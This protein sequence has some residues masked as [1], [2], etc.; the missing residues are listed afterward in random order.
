MSSDPRSSLHRGF[1]D[2]ASDVGEGDRTPMV[3][4]KFRY[5]NHR[6]DEHEYIIRPERLHFDRCGCG[7]NPD[8]LNWLISGWIVSRDGDRRQ[9]LILPQ[10]RRRSF[11]LYNMKCIDEVNELDLQ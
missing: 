9:E 1:P 11:V 8:E 10:D 6:G 7:P 3:L 5:K 4:L 2:V